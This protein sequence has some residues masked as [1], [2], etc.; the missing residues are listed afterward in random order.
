MALGMIV[1]GAAIGGAIGLAKGG[2]R[3]P[4]KLALWGG[5]LGL[6]ASFLSPKRGGF[7]SGQLPQSLP[8]PGLPGQLVYNVDPRRDPLLDPVSREQLYPDWLLLH[9][10]HGDPKIVSQV[11]H[12]LGVA[13]DG[14]IGSTTLAAIH[15]FQAHAGLP[16]TG[17]MD[18]MTMAAL[19]PG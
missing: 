5:G 3:A 15:A 17:T 2:K 9:W 6:V 16:V 8:Q 19:I 4:M 7:L 14:V 13:P 1:A 11:Q 18:R 12:A 10:Q